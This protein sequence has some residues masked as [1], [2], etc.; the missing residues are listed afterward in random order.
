[1]LQ[2]CHLRLQLDWARVREREKS[3]PRVLENVRLCRECI[4]VLWCL[5]LVSLLLCGGGLLITAGVWRGR[6]PRLAVEVQSICLTVYWLAAEPAGGGSGG[7][8]FLFPSWNDAR[9]PFHSVFWPQQ[10]SSYHFCD[11]LQAVCFRT[12]WADW[13]ILPIW[14]L[15]MIFLKESA[16]DQVKVHRCYE[17]CLEAI[18]HS[19]QMYQF[20]TTMKFSK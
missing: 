5:V 20:R 6:A 8:T 2:L 15:Y 4:C 14:A 12:G 18:F 19:F 9:L 16:W 7:I 17:W 10:N 13:Q 1:M 11:A 3:I